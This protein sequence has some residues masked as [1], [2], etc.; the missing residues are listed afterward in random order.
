MGPPLRAQ[1]VLPVRARGGRDAYGDVVDCSISVAGEVD[2]Y[3]FTG[4]SGERVRVV[5]ASTSQ[6]GPWLQVL[7]PDGTVA[8]QDSWGSPTLIQ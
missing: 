4:V 5:M 3:A 1:R 2:T 6:V 8:C 7:R